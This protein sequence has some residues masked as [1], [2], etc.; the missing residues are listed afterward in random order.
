MDVTG[1]RRVVIVGNGGAGKSTLAAE[2]GRALGLPVVHLDQR[3]W[4]P[5]WAPTPDDEWEAT[6]RALVAAD[7]WVMDGNYGGTMELRFAAADTILFLD[8]PRLLCTWRAFRRGFT[9]RG[10]TRADMAPGCPERV[11]VGFLRWV[12]SY[13]SRVRPRV[14]ALLSQLP[15]STNVVVLR[16]DADANALIQ[17]ATGHP[18]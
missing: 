14:H 16:G 8:Y 9:Q 1:A 13:N 11:D 12:W 3:F 6:V 2:L 17:R 10:R 5:G 15:A 4:R 7:R 18:G